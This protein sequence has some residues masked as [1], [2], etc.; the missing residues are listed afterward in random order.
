MGP[1]HAPA[2][3][4]RRGAVAATLIAIAASGAAAGPARA[5]DPR[6]V[7]DAL[8]ATA[9]VVTPVVGT[10]VER[11]EA[12]VPVVAPVTGRMRTTVEAVRAQAPVRSALETVRAPVGRATAGAEPA[13]R[14]AFAQTGAVTTSPGFGATRPVRDAAGPHAAGEIDRRASR[15]AGA[16]A[17]S[18]VAD[19][20]TMNRASDPAPVAILLAAAERAESAASSTAARGDDGAPNGGFPPFGH[21]GGSALGGPAGIALLAI[22]LLAALLTLVPRFSS[23]LL[24]MSPARWG[25]AVFLVPIERPD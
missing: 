7:A 24:H 6:P 4:S 13:V 11:V 23:R 18:G 17:P 22:G 19:A 21:D 14:A 2:R 9:Q 12:A 16:L 15:R 25:P 10:A 20:L 8:K 1:L 5:D 3:R